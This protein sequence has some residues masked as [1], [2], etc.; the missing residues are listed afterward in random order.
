MTQTILNLA[1][2]FANSVEITEKNFHLIN[3][4][5]FKNWLVQNLDKM[6]DNTAKEAKE[7][8]NPT[9]VKS[10]TDHYRQR[11]LMA[12]CGWAWR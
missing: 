5:N 1:T 6:S 4:D 2:S 9:E 10:D 3:K 7:F 12:N 8:L 11:R